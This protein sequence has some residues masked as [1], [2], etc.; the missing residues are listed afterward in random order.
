MYIYIYEERERTYKYTHVC[1]SFYSIWHRFK[2]IKN[3]SANREMHRFYRCPLFSSICR[4][5][6][7]C[8]DNAIK[9][10]IFHFILQ[11]LFH[12]R[13]FYSNNFIQGLIDLVY[14]RLTLECLVKTSGQICPPK[15]PRS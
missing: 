13:K 5:H 1:V 15:N 11:R 3:K 2:K 12:N 9:V 4:S 10:L 6:L 8:V 14:Q 7:S